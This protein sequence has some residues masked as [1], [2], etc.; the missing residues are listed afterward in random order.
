MSIIFCLS[1]ST[2][3]LLPWKTFFPPELLFLEIIFIAEE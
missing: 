3:T 1:V 2:L